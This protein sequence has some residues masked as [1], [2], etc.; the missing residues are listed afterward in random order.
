MYSVYVDNNLLYSPDLANDGYVIL[1]PHAILETNKAG[2]FSF[3]LPPNNPLYDNIQKLVSIITVWDDADEIFRGR[4]LYDD[5]DFYN[6]KKVYCEGELSFLLDS[7][8]RPYDFSGDIPVLFNQFITNHNNQVEAAKRF[9]VG[10]VTVTDPNNYIVR[11]SSSYPKTWDEM[12]DKFLNL[13]GGYFRTRKVGSTRYIDYVAD[14]GHVSNQIIEF[15]VN[16][17]DISEYISAENVFTCLIPLGRS[18]DNEVKLTIA[19][20]N[21]GKDYLIDE[22]AVRLFGYVWKS[23]EWDD[24][25]IPSNLLTKGREYLQSGIEL[26]VS[27]TMN[28]VD[29]HLLNVETERISIGDM[30][31]VISIPHRIDRYFMCTKIRLDLVNPDMSEYTFG[32]TFTTMSEKSLNITGN[33]Q[34][35]SSAASAAAAAAQNAASQAQEAA[36]DARQ[37]VVDIPTE[38][39]KTTTFE[40]FQQEVNSKISAVYH[41]KGSVQDYESLPL[42]NEIGD[43]YNLQDTGANYV[44]TSNGWDKLS[45]T[46]DLSGYVPQATYDALESRVAALE[47]LIGGNEENE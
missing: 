32:F 11:A 27:L 19:S 43:V 12:N 40:A 5:K 22:D 16:M 34:N 2:T 41:V 7:I 9:T 20:V 1:N 39:V 37:T 14:Y 10:N 13:L 45:E 36:D 6:R 15:G 31:R 8:V 28:A 25:T 44:W 21:D 3:L 24:V 47:N 33:V 23:Q 30:V 26:A 29:L 4:V 18:D 38:Y 17:L 35:I 42:I 46:V